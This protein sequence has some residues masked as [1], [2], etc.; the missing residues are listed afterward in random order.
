MTRPSFLFFLGCL[1]VTH[2]FV[3][4]NHGAAM[5]FVQRRQQQQKQQQHQKTSS[6]MP[7]ISRGGN[8]LLS[9]PLPTELKAPPAIYE[10]AVALG[11]AK[12]LSSP[13]K[14]FTLGICAGI[15]IAFG[16]YLAI[17]VGGN[18]P[19]FASTNPGIQKLILGGMGL[20][21]GLIM[22][23]VSGAELFTGNTALVT[24]A[25]MEGKISLKDLFKNWF[26]SF[27]GNLV[28]S[29]LIAYLAFGSGT[30]GP[31]PGA[32]A[33][34][35]AKCNAPWLASFYKGILCNF[36]VC[37]AVYMASGASS[38]PGKMSTFIYFSFAPFRNKKNQTSDTIKFFVCFYLF[39]AILFFLLDM[40][41]SQ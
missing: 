29:L 1:A 37:M 13:S 35:V 3:A 28:G 24:A 19:G 15:H 2:A 5:T 30:L 33:M 36:L 22:T 32:A 9:T 31:A 8:V 21:T 16:A 26:C 18:L 38:L 14:I 40:D 7:L 27:S 23:L 12:G 34:A 20:P 41:M 4:G 39:C 10:G 25:Y 6:A 17:S 11:T